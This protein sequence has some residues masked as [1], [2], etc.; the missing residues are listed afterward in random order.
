MQLY[1]NV[2]DYVLATGMKVGKLVDAATSIKAGQDKASTD[3]SNAI[4]K[5]QAR[6]RTRARWPRVRIGAAGP[7]AGCGVVAV[8]GLSL[9]RR[10][11]LVRRL[12][13]RWGVSRRNG[14]RRYAAAAA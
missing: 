5:L 13:Q 3:Q 10:S 7:P 14:A 12:G 1:N 2:S 11:A 8:P 6:T 9:C 4:A